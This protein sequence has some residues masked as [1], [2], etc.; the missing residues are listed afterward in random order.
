MATIQTAFR[1][2]DTFV[3]MM[4]KRARLRNQ[5][6]NSYVKDVISADLRQAEVLPPIQLPQI[7]DEDI[8]QFSGSMRL[9]K[10]EELEADERLNRIW[11]K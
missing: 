5:S 2:E 1:F 10:P 6:L 3:L 4:K 7:L 11:T 8:R 9:P